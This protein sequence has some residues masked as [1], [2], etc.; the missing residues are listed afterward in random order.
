MEEKDFQSIKTDTSLYNGQPTTNRVKKTS[1]LGLCRGAKEEGNSQPTEI[2]IH[3]QN[4]GVTSI[5]PSIPKNED[6]VSIGNVHNLISHISNN[7][8][9]QYESRIR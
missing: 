5:M 7:T 8:L 6:G 4:V 1:S 2:G 9:N 3:C